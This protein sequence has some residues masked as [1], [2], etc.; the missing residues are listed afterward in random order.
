[1]IAP[2]IWG[3]LISKPNY[4]KGQ[5]WKPDNLIVLSSRFIINTFIKL[6]AEKNPGPVNSKQIHWPLAQLTANNSVV[7]GNRPRVGRCPRL[8]DRQ[9]AHLCRDDT[10]NL[11]SKKKK[12]E[13]C[14][15]MVTSTI[16]PLFQIVN[17][18]LEEH[19][20]GIYCL[21]GAENIC[22]YTCFNKSLIKGTVNVT[23]TGCCSSKENNIY[24]LL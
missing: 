8:H 15:C 2:E 9:I 21:D 19:K 18:M 20:R 6:I 22:C 12:R 11:E 4:H 7:S 23:A 24:Y 16:V 17:V 13:K 14:H 5:V 10:G 1:M 3:A